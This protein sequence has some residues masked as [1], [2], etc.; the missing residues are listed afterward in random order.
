[1][2]FQCH[3]GRRL[4]GYDLSGFVHHVA[5]CGTCLH[6]GPVSEHQVHLSRAAAVLVGG[7][8]PVRDSHI[9]NNSSFRFSIK[10]IYKEISN[11][12]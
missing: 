4:V 6:L 3:E 12:T 10:N 11:V 9:S 2:D 7:R 8:V 5:R 1:M